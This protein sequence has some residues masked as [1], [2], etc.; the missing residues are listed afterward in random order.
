MTLVHLGGSNVPNALI[1]IDTYGQ[2]EEE[3]RTS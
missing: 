2:V 3:R 1:S